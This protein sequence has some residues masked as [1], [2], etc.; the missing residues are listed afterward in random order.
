MEGNREGRLYCRNYTATT[1]LSLENSMYIFVVGFSSLCNVIRGEAG[2]LVYKVHKPP[3]PLSLS[4]LI[5]FV[6]FLKFRTPNSLKT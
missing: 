4:L 3:P 1:K 6:V 2:V 5:L